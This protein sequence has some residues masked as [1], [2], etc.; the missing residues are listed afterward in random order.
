MV[1][2]DLNRFEPKVFTVVI[3]TTLSLP[4]IKLVFSSPLL[5][6]LLIVLYGFFF[7]HFY[8]VTPVRINPIQKVYISL[9]LAFISLVFISYFIFPYSQHSLDK[10]VKY[11]FVFIAV[12]ATATFVEKID[13]TLLINLL[14]AWGLILCVW[15]L[16]LGISLSFDKGQTYLTYGMPIGCSLMLLLTKVFQK[17]TWKE[18]FFYGVLIL[19]NIFVILTSRG[20]SSI[21]FPFLTFFLVVFAAFFV[22]NNKKVASKVVLVG[23]I[24]TLLAGSYVLANLES[25]KSLARVIALVESGGEDSRLSLWI[26]AVEL[27]L[28][29]PFGYGTDAHHYLLRH[30]PH[31]IFLEITLAYGLVGLLMFLGILIVFSDRFIKSF[32][33]TPI[34]I[35]LMGVGV[36]FFLSWNTS[37]DLATSTIPFVAF[38][39]S[40]K[41]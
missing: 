38:T 4:S 16:T 23:A 33:K 8:M 26:P 25:F 11:F 15:K 21:I 31:N 30:Y 36:Y 24:I 39:I 29:N 6:A 3:F 32:Y 35:S 22:G 10:Y 13:I 37:H 17:L 34:Y 28:K 7:V 40:L 18:L 41:S 5:N 14:I 27:I 2:L 9:F 20:R 12:L 19:L 1:Q